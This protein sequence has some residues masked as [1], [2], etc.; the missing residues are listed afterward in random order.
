[1][2]QQ[3][4]ISRQGYSG[5]LRIVNCPRRRALPITPTAVA[6]FVRMKALPER[7]RVFDP[8]PPDRWEYE[9]CKAFRKLHGKSDGAHECRAFEPPAAQPPDVEPYCWD[10]PCSDPP[11]CVRAWWLPLAPPPCRE[12]VARNCP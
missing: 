2:S 4:A 7:S 10:P 1:M 9:A 11:K 12:L 5:I 6:V 8:Q 3:F